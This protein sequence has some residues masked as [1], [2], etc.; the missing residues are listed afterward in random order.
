MISVNSITV[1]FG[2]F[3]LLDD[4]SF[5]V[6][7]RDRI[8]L[9]G[10]NGAGKTTLLRIIAGKHKPSSGRITTPSGLTIGYLPQQMEISDHTTVLNESLKAFTKVSS[11]QKSI[12]EIT[13]EISHRKDYESE[14]Y[15]RA[16][17]RLS[18][19]QEDYKICG[20]DNIYAETEIALTGL[21]FNRKDFDK[22]TNQLSGGWR[23]RIELAK[24]ILTKPSLILLD[25]PTNHLDIESIEW[26]EGFLKTYPGEV[27]LVSHDRAFLDNITNR[28][29]EISLARVYDYKVP[30]STYTK[31][32][33]ERREQQL[34]AYRNQ[35]KMIDS[36]EKFIERFRYKNT[37]AIQ[38]QSRIKHLDKLERIELDDE[39]SG[40]INIR[41]EPSPRSGTIVVETKN[42]SKSYGD[43]LVLNEIDLVIE[44]GEKVA[45]VG[46]NGEGKTTL[47]RIIMNEIDYEG[48]LK[49][50]HNLRIGYF[51]QNQDELLDENM[52]VFQTIDNIAVGDIRTRIRDILGAFLFS[53]DDIEKKVKVLS[54]GERSRLALIKLL[55]EPYNLLL[56]DE[57]TNHLDIRSKDILKQALLKFDGTLIVVSHDRDFLDGLVAKVYEFHNKKVKEH[58]G[59]VYEFLEK[60]K[61]NSLK[62]LERNKKIINIEEDQESISISKL[63]YLEKKE[64]NRKIRKLEKELS[65]LEDNIEK[66]EKERE[67]M[68]IILSSPEKNEELRDGAFFKKYEELKISIDNNLTLWEDKSEQLEKTR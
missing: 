49:T 62:Q 63:S 58:R 27:I 55:L 40:K 53:G 4:V 61:L 21:G 18:D 11:L 16:C 66:L 43:N 36:T 9:T 64:E 38:V 39:D 67:E 35:K 30:Y 14:S 57:P 1:N 7:S 33:E 42:L 56:L 54:G 65:E 46:K 26:L 51:A 68:E 45:F 24:I 2:S 20:G 12:D 10:K 15:M 50:G 22:P 60:K 44:R 41:F 28:T 5:L 8:G 25:E 23:M 6:N 48:E 19:L 31:Q 59:S 17:D 29:I 34:A 32:R 52:T 3:T 13:N 37:K 47:S